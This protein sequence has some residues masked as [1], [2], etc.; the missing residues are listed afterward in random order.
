MVTYQEIASSSS[1]SVSS[2]SSASVA[3][4]K[5]PVPVPSSVGSLWSPEKRLTL[6]EKKRLLEDLD[7]NGGVAK[8][9]KQI[10]TL[11]NA[12]EDFY[13]DRQTVAGQKR[14]KQFKNLVNQWLIKV[15][16]GVF[17]AERERVSAAL[18]VTVSATPGTLRSPRSTKPA[19]KLQ[20]SS[21]TPSKTPS[22]MSTNNE[23]ADYTSDDDGE[24]IDRALPGNVLF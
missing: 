18:P 2:D 20:T 17:E 23:L 3:S 6:A 13:G 9:G 10:A 1:S 8:A 4:S 5:T 7:S 19:A 15:E 16:R 21:K 11:L 12:D 22:K 14:R 24:F